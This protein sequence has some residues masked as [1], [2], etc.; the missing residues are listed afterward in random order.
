MNQEPFGPVVPIRKFSE[1]Q[2]VVQEANRLSYNLAAFAFTKSAQTANSISGAIES[3]MVPINHH[4]L[5][6][7]EAPNAGV[8]ESGYG[9]E[10]G[11]EALEAYLITK[12]VA[13]AA[14]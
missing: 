1:Y 7:P 4:G 13:H 8:K 11:Y 2:E 6:L 10:G 3:G 5:G 14:L 12:F 9:A